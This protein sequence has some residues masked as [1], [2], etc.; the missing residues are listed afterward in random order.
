M[1]SGDS[2]AESDR[3]CPDARVASCSVTSGGPSSRSSCRYDGLGSLGGPVPGRG[4]RPGRAGMRRRARSAGGCVARGS[5][6][7]CAQP[8]ASPR[9]HSRSNPASRSRTAP[10]LHRRTRRVALW[11]ARHRRRVRPGRLGP[12]HLPQRGGPLGRRPGQV[13]Q[14]FRRLKD[15]DGPCIVGSGFDRDDLEKAGATRPMPWPP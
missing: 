8:W 4:D 14:A 1:Q 9:P 11:R 7:P 2:T 10:L 3:S 12:R 5:G 6:P 13:R 15:W